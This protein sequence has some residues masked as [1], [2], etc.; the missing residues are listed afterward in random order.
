M[1]TVLVQKRSMGLDILKYFCALMVICI[2]IEY[3]GKS[4]LEPL[5]R[6][7]VPVFFMVTGYFCDT[8]Y[9]RCKVCAQIKKIAWMI[10]ISNCVYAVWNVLLYMTKGGSPVDYLLGLLH[11]KRLLPFL[12]LNDSPMAEHLWYIGAL[13]YVW[14]IV[15]VADRFCW[16]RHLYLLIPVLLLANWLLG[17]FSGVIL[18]EPLEISLSRNFLF[19]GLPC[20]LLGSY[21]R[22]NNVRVKSIYCIIIMLLS[23][24][25]TVLENCL[26]L[27][28]NEA[29][30]KD[31]YFATPFFAVALFLLVLGNEEHFS[32]KAATLLASI[33]RKTILTVYIVH[34]LVSAVMVKAVELIGRKVPVVSTIYGYVAPLC[35]ML[36]ST[37]FAL[38][39]SQCARAARNYLHPVAK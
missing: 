34:P 6:F 9:Q 15:L 30:N 19:S 14:I 11:Y 37:V 17:N 25:L 28:T 2:H 39:L 3:S 8:V 26:L 32:G 5:T 29:N 20:F 16:R 12:L 24:I 4:M 22:Q 31:F 10:I 38:V 7:A 27:G 13:L 36:A 21:I 1:E 18:S 33:A 35:V 23:A